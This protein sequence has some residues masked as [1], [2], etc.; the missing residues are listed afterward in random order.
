MN[1]HESFKKLLDLMIPGDPAQG[2]PA[3]SEVDISRAL[4]DDTTVNELTELSLQ[5]E[6]LL[7][8]HGKS[9]ARLEDA[10][11]QEF[12]RQ[13]RAAADPLLRTIGRYLLMGYYTDETVRAAIGVGSRAP[14]PLGYAVHEGNL[15][16]L[17][18]VFER[19]PIF[20]EVHH[21]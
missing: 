19:G 3:G 17:E 9:L 2:L 10:E 13:H 14:F 8:E 5:I 21:E 16:L 7:T 15:E 20:R 6:M 18:P 12:I 11:F 4:I 1:A